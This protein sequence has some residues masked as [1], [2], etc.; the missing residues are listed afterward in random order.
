MSN[1]YILR[2]PQP[3]DMGMVVHKHGV[4]YAQEY[5]KMSLISLL[6]DKTTFR[7]T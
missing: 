4:L 7:S 2:Q 3:G 1:T 5:G 6:R